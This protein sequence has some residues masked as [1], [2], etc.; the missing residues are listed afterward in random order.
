MYTLTYRSVTECSTA[1]CSN[2]NNG[3]TT[4]YEYQSCDGVNNIGCAGEHIHCNNGL[5]DLCWCRPEHCHKHSPVWCS[6]D[7]F[8]PRAEFSICVTDSIMFALKSIKSA[9]SEP[10][11]CWCSIERCESTNSNKHSTELYI[12][13]LNNGANDRQHNRPITGNYNVWIGHFLVAALSKSSPPHYQT[14]A[15]H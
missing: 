8:L 9:V 11:S 3:V 4:Y 12:A 2:Y 13:V 1:T 15:A 7:F 5:W 6:Q 10:R 14:I